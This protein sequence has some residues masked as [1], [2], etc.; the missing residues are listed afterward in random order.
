LE[1]PLWRLVRASTAAPAYFPPEV[2]EVGGQ[3]FVF[4]DGGVTTYNNP[5][6]LAFLMATV[7]R[8][9]ANTGQAG[10]PANPTWP[11]QT[12]PDKL[13]VISVGCGASPEARAEITP[14]DMHYG[15]TIANVY[16]MLMYAALVEQ[17]VLC[18]VFGD[19]LAGDPI[20]RELLDLIGEQGRGPVNPKLFT[21][22]RY[23]AELSK[24]GLKRLD[25]GHIDPKHVNRLDAIEAVPE[26]REIGRAI[27]TQ[28]VK[29]EHFAGFPV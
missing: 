14:S 24:E 22:A 13:L 11:A 5:A 4:V 7:K 28:V 17:D 18:R 12:G 20:D 29:P 27:A 25:C 1:L 8:Y 23:T 15:Y 19:C 26:L 10:L 9:W 6:F 21:Y 2:V 3:S 16:S